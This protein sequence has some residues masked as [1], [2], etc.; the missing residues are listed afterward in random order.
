MSVLSAHARCAST[1]KLYILKLPEEFV[2]VTEELK[3]IVDME[4]GF[5]EFSGYVEFTK[6]SGPDFTVLL[7]IDYENGI[8]K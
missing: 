5:K 4:A 1:Q 6:G 3:N 7:R 8:R 2:E